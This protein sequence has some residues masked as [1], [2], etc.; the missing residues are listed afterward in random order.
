MRMYMKKKK[1][2]P[3]NCERRT[4]RSSTV[5]DQDELTPDRLQL[6][7]QQVLHR[8][9]TLKLPSFGTNP[10]REEDVRSPT[11]P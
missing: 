1:F 7:I 8:G 5:C 4:R 9:T 11:S 3:T 2:C 10:T 6:K